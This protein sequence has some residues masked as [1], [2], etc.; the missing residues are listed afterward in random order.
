MFLG[1]SLLSLLATGKAYIW[2]SPQLEALDSIRF[3]LPDHAQ[4]GVDNFLEPCDQF[5]LAPRWVRF[6]VQRR[7]LVAHDHDMATHSVEDGT[8]GLD[9]SI[10][11][12]NAGTG[13]KNTLTVV[14][15]N[16]N[17]YVSVTDFIAVAALM[18]VE[19]CGGPEIAYRGGRLDATAP[20]SPGV[21]RPEQDLDPHIASFVQ[22]GF[23]PTEMISLIACGH[24]FGGVEHAPFPDIVP[25]LNDSNDTHTSTA[26][27]LTS[28][29]TAMEYISGTTQNSLAVGANDTTNSD[30]RIFGSDGNV[31]MRGQWPDRFANSPELFPSTYA[32]FFARMIDT[33]PSGVQLTDVVTPL[34]IKPTVSIILDGDTLKLST[35][36]WNMSGDKHVQLLLDDCVGGTKS[37]TLDALGVT[38][39]FNG[40]YSVAWYAVN[41]TA[42]TTARI[43]S[44]RF[45][46]DGKLEDQGGIGFALQD[47]IV[48]S[49]TSCAVDA[50]RTA[51]RF[52]VAMRAR[53]ELLQFD[54]TSHPFIVETDIPRPVQP[55]A[56]N[57]D[58][59]IWSVNVS[60]P[61]PFN[62]GFYSIG[63]EVDGVKTSTVDTHSLVEVFPCVT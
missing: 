17:R 27:L 39:A 38:S 5:L 16:S 24:S 41:A 55:V 63:A 37:V 29:I 49:N 52:D 23:T 50:N 28:T 57:G 15:P 2:P 47:G 26:P 36:F 61:D 46:V 42:D 8:G 51:G 53:D 13:F 35:E 4:V 14:A 9:A 56:A 60:D 3:G 25:E 40:R 54:N 6:R 48:F 58:Y 11:R 10:R 34:P 33:V 1:L 31:T 59:S 21:L 62:P 18:A 32:S 20:N 44:I 12:D 22:Q 45:L 7:R 19:A 43:T 30:K